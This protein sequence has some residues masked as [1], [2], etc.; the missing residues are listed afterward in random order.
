MRF[1]SH[2]L[3]SRWDYIFRFYGFKTKSLFLIRIIQKKKKN[4]AIWKKLFWWFSIFYTFLNNKKIRKFLDILSFWCSKS[5][6]F[7]WKKHSLKSRAVLFLR[8]TELK[9]NLRN[10]NYGSYI[11][12]PWFRSLL[13]AFK[14]Y[15][16][17]I[18]ARIGLFKKIFISSDRHIKF[19]RT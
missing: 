14:K 5:S 13:Q 6:V 12:I 18:R 2:E 1:E 7:L 8:Q 19:V 9:I 11:Q 17:G 10:N 3:N 4:I 15:V 16:R